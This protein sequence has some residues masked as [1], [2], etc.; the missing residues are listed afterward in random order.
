[1]I[2]CSYKI[3]MIDFKELQKE[4]FRNKEEK[5]FNT[6][7]ISMEFA[8][9]YGEMSEAYEAYFLKKDDIGEELADVVIYI[10]GL[11]EM[12]GVD[13]ENELLNKVE[14][15][16]KRVYKVVNGVSIKIKEA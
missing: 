1:M 5:K 2:V 8:L 3:D 13:L 4:I 15:N 11:A 7:D 16:K 6:T 12:L 14:K 9:A 10:L